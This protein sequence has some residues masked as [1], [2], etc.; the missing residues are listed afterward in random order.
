[1]LAEDVVCLR[2]PERVELGAVDRQGR[3]DPVRANASESAQAFH[4]L[5]SDS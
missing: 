1:M 4:R 5:V 2:V 3:A